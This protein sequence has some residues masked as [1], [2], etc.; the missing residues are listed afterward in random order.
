MLEIAESKRI[1]DE[2][3][4][5]DILT[6]FKERQFQA[7][8]VIAADVCIYFGDLFSL[9]S[10]TYQHSKVNGWFVFSCEEGVD[11]DIF[12]LT[13]TGRYQH[14]KPYVTKILQQTQW[15]LIHDEAVTLRQQQGKAVL[16]RVYLCYKK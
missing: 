8:A 7:D 15:Q 4:C 12:H 1:Y 11:D 6:I 16:G 3:I 2:L 10:A 13:S 9:F 5:G 14:G